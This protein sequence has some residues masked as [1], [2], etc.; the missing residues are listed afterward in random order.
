MFE[1]HSE[2]YR[3]KP[4]PPPF[5]GNVVWPTLENGDMMLFPDNCTD[6]LQNCS[7]RGVC[8]HHHKKGI[9][10]L[11]VG[12]YYGEV[13]ENDHSEIPLWLILAAIVSALVVYLLIHRFGAR[14]KLNH[15]SDRNWAAYQ[16]KTGNKRGGHLEEIRENLNNQNDEADANYVSLH[17]QRSS[18]YET[19]AEL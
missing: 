2:Y 3:L 9:V 7:S 8:A 17:V 6:E 19:I 16:T 18:K 14:K 1:N 5:P 4:T 10:C 12:D 11:C 13:C 15:T